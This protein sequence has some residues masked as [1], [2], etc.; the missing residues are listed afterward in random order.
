MNVSF[1]EHCND[2]EM[3]SLEMKGKPP[4]LNNSCVSSTVNHK[5]K[6]SVGSCFMI[7]F[8]RA[9]NVFGDFDIIYC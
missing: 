9:K 6:T 5:P 1:L 7:M 8:M 2:L 4:F 3:S